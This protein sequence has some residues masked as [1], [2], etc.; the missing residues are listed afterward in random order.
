MFFPSAHREQFL[1]YEGRNHGFSGLVSKT[2]DVF[3]FIKP[4]AV[5]ETHVYV[6]G[7][8]FKC[9]RSVRKFPHIYTKQ[10]EKALNT[11]IIDDLDDICVEACHTQRE[12]KEVVCLRKQ[13]SLRHS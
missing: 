7:S 13:L 5:K 3:Y 10:A 2:P 1:F 8:L 4:P 12:H 6:R 11:E 9:Q